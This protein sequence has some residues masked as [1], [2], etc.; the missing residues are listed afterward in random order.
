MRNVVD[1]SFTE[2]STHKRGIVDSKPI[3]YS[4]QMIVSKTFKN[5]TKEVIFSFG[6][7]F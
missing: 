5:A 2:Q 4:K 6:N 7:R 3:L 1:C